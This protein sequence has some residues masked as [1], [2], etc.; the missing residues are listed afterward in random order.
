LDVTWREGRSGERKEIGMN[1]YTNK[2]ERKKKCKGINDSGSKGWMTE[3]R[4]LAE[5]L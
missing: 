2:E 5:A 3:V 1:K 4:F